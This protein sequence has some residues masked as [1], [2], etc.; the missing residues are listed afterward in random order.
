MNVQ[1]HPKRR[2]RTEMN[3]SGLRDCVTVGSDMLY[4][5]Q[6]M[7]AQITATVKDCNKP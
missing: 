2:S 6:E 3:V 7:K 4:Q 5:V 1:A